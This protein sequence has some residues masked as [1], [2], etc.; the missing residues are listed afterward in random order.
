MRL[1][2]IYTLEK[3]LI[4][5]CSDCSGMKLLRFGTIG[6]YETGFV[7]NAKVKCDRRKSRLIEY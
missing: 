6:D 2:I 4:P 3:R 1:T 5:G 7:V